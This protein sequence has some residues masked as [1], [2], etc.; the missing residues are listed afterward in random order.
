MTDMFPTWIESLADDE[1]RRV[2]WLLIAAIFLILV[3]LFRRSLNNWREG[4]RIARAAGRLGARMLRNVRLP[5]GMG[6]EIGIDFLA[7][8]ADAILVIGV[9]RYDGFIFGSAQ[10]DEWTQNLRNHSYKFPNPD[11]CLQRQVGAVK[12]LVP[13]IPVRGV[14]LVAD[15]AVFPRDKPANVLQ[16]SDL[17]GIRRPAVQE[18]PTQLQTA[19]AGLAHELA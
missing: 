8:A 19:W 1:Q 4:R 15:S 13:G 12:I 6:E 18:I 7:L 2:T 17:C 9:K 3:Y 10:T 14:H 11:V 5:D 16:V